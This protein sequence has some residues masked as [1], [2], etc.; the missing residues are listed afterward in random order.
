MPVIPTFSGTVRQCNSDATFE[1]AVSNAVDGDIIEITSN[2]SFLSDKTISKRL[3]FISQGSNIYTLLVNSANCPLTI[4][5][6]GCVVQNLA[7]T[8]NDGNANAQCLAFVNINGGCSGWVDGCVINTNE[9]GIV[10]N[11]QYTYITNNTFNFVGTADNN[12]FLYINGCKNG[13]AIM[14]NN[15]FNGNSG[16]SSQCCLLNATYDLYINSSFEMSNN[17]A[18]NVQRLFMSESDY[19]GGNVSFYFN[20]NTV[21]GSSGFAIFYNVN[22]LYGVNSIYALNN[23]YTLAGGATGSK[24]L[25]GCDNISST[26]AKINTLVYVYAYN[27]VNIPVLRSPDYTDMTSVSVYNDV[28]TLAY[29]NTI[30]VPPSAFPFGTQTINLITPKLCQIASLT[31]NNN[32]A[33]LT[34]LANYVNKD[35]TTAMTGNLNLN[36]TNKIINLSA[37]T[38]STDATNKNYVDTQDNLLLPLSGVRAMTGNLD[39]GVLNKITN[40]SAPV[41]LYDATNKTYVDT[42]NTNTNNILVNKNG[43]TAM[44]GNLNLNS[45]KIINLADPTLTADAST[46]NYTDTQ[47]NLLLPLSGVRAMTGNLNMGSTNRI[48]NLGVGLNGS[49]AVTKSQMDASDALFLTLSGSRTMTGALNMGT[50]NKIINLATPTNATDGATKAYVDAQIAGGGGT[51]SRIIMTFGSTGDPNFL[52]G[53]NPASTYTSTGNNFLTNKG[54]CEALCYTSSNQAFVN[55][56][57][58]INSNNTTDYSS[59]P[60]GQNF[61]IGGLPSPNYFFADGTTR[62]LPLIYRN[63]EYSLVSSG[64]LPSASGKFNGSDA[65]GQLRYQLYTNNVAGNNGYLVFFNFD[66]SISTDTVKSSSTGI[67]QGQMQFSI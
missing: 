16:F 22:C 39:M 55:I 42:L 2:F 4:T 27:N 7:L 64:G 5:V 32:Y 40:L 66:G 51:F 48:T 28:R 53:S 36:T 29:N 1:S 17:T 8:N 57:F 15:I 52:V 20:A 44:T 62:Q 41:N 10:S 43:T 24:G 50:T 9:F 3:L 46:K 45:N 6:S 67:L 59:L 11:F 31:R 35:G 33:T 13:S 34:Q 58:R 30:F 26:N 56:N 23:V 54:Y 12:R 19:T 60:S 61:A 63:F 37:P 65:S 47:D 14:N 21:S 18:I 49:D 25:I 38:L